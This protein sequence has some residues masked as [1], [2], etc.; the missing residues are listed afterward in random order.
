MSISVIRTEEGSETRT[1][2]TNTTSGKSAWPVTSREVSF[3][4]MG[5]NSKSEAFDAVLDASPEVEDG[6]LRKSVRFDGFDGEGVLSFTAVYEQQTESASAGAGGDSR[7]EPQMSFD[8]S[9][10][11]AHIVRSLKQTKHAD[12]PDPDGM[13]GWNGKNGTEAEYAGVDVVTSTMR[14]SYTVQMRPSQLT[15]AY[16]RMLANLTGT[17]NSKS[18]KGWEAGEVLFLG[19]SFSG[20]ETGSERI[21]VTYNFAIQQNETGVKVTDK[22]TKDKKGWE[23]IWTIPK[24]VYDE[25]TKKTK[26][27]VKNVFIE[28]V[29]RYEDFGKLKL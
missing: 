9:G 2:T 12:T 13:I 5:A 24:Q 15:T 29:Y 10:G 16:K 17:V 20:A 22:I 6:L 23:Y 25:A 11:T 18:F 14:E 7:E 3:L 19:A 4:V 26:V 21:T 27:D 8:C 28:Q 1:H